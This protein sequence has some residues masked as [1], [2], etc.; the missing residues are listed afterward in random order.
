MERISLLAENTWLTLRKSPGFGC[1][2]GCVRHVPYRDRTFFRSS[3]SGGALI[4]ARRSLSFFF[5]FRFFLSFASQLSIARG[6]QVK[7]LIEPRSVLFRTLRSRRPCPCSTV[8]LASPRLSAKSGPG[9]TPRRPPSRPPAY[10][11][12]SAARTLSLIASRRC[13]F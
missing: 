3:A 8:L 1:W 2:H 5:F 7:R 11:R 13:V 9:A 12:I 6:N 4:F 10:S